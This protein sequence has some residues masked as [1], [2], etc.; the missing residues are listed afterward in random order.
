MIKVL[1]VIGTLAGVRETGG[2]KTG[3]GAI[4]PIK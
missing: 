1:A 4:A 3:R 2:R